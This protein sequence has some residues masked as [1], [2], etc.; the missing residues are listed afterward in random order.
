M[1]TKCPAT[2][3][4][5]AIAGETNACVRLC[6][7]DPRSSDCSWPRTFARRKHVG[8]HRQTHAAT[9][10]APLHTR[11]AENLVE[12]FG[13]R[14]TLDQSAAGH[15]HGANAL[16]HAMA[17]NHFG[18]RTMSSIRPLVHEPMNT[19]SIGIDMIGVPGSRAMYSSA[20]ATALRSVGSANSAGSGTLP[21]ISVTWAG[22][23]PQVTC[24]CTSPARNFSTRSYFAPGSLGNCRHRPTAA[25]KS[26]GANGPPRR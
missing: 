10:L 25:A 1:S 22:V 9:G 11:L 13:L 2:A 17:A 4:A 26:F 24:G 5:A 7:A 3:A 15:D 18:R 12:P 21:P 20:A 14:L 8:I 16:G 6:P 19:R 23:V